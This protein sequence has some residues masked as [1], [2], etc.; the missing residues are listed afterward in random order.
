MNIVVQEE[1]NTLT[2]YLMWF[3]HFLSML[4]IP[5][6]KDKC[7]NR[8]KRIKEPTPS[9]SKKFSSYK[10]KLDIVN[11]LSCQDTPIIEH[12][13]RKSPTKRIIS[14]YIPKIKCLPSKM[15]LNSKLFCLL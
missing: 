7:L 15:Q 3:S 2:H 6:K 8:F 10:V 12:S 1:G 4:L 14:K 9:E 13:S 11:N 5:K